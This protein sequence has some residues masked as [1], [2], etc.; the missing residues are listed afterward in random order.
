MFKASNNTVLLLLT[1]FT[2]ESELCASHDALTT[3]TDVHLSFCKTTK[4]KNHF[5]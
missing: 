2:Q 1:L 5:I 4:G 3:E